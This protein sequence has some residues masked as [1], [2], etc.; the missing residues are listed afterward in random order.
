MIWNYTIVQFVTICKNFILGGEMIYSQKYSDKNYF[1]FGTL[2]CLS[3]AL[4]VLITGSLGSSYATHMSENITWQLIFLSNDKGCTNYQ[5]QMAD[6]Y[7]EITKKYFE[8]YQFA[9]TKYPPQCMSD[10][11]YSAYKVP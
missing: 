3:L 2:A 6:T 7:D 1:S 10:S 4:A 5:Y 8:L 11:K 9:N